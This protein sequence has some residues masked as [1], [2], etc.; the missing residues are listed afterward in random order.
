VA[1]AGELVSRTA[2]FIHG[3]WMTPRCWESWSTFF[4]SRGYRCLAP[5]W[6]YHERPVEELRRSPAP[7]LGRLGAAEIVDHYARIVR[8]LDEPPVLIG[9]SFGGLWVQCLLDRGLGS[10]GVAIDSAPPRGVLP[11]QWPALRSSAGVLVTVAP[12]RVVRLSFAQ[13]RYAFAHT[14]PEAVQRAA[15]ERHVVP[16]TR[17]I[18][19]QAAGALFHPASPVRVDFRNA[20]RPPLLLI[21][22]A[23]DHIV[24]AAQN[25]SNFA[26]FRGSGARTEFREFPGRTHWI[27]GQ[28]G[29]EE[30]A[31][32]VADWL[33]APPTG[34]TGVPA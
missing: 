23:A 27:I 1:A 20:R 29:W 10:A 6:P 8:G 5:A 32:F 30:V 34:G 18:F 2:V 11:I 12:H 33:E 16:E 15:Y 19:F 13:F 28:E 9:H 31:Q 22:G 26:R 21:A 3:A 25:R 24:P 14:I 4:T 17:R 7:E